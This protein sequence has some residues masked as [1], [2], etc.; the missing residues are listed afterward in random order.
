MDV[1]LSPKASETRPADSFSSRRWISDLLSAFQSSNLDIL[2]SSHLRPIDDLRKPFTDAFLMVFDEIGA[3][4]PPAWLGLREDL[5]ELFE[6]AVR[7][8]ERGVSFGVDMVVVV[9]RKPTN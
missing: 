9:G 3:N 7:E 8:T 2:A 1:V 4:A 6:N 5:Q